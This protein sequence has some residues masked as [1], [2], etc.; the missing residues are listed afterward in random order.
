MNFSNG[1]LRVYAH[2]GIKPVGTLSETAK[3]LGEILAVSFFE[4]KSGRFDE[5]PA[6]IAEATHIRYALLGNPDPEEDLRDDP[7]E[8]FE[9][10]IEPRDQ[11]LTS[12]KADKSDE[13]V[14]I[15]SLDGRI[16]CWVLR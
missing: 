6:F 16:D 2:V 10:V 12:Q 4:D 9:L 7:T 5:F 8:D 1:S 13:L 14:S 11:T 3:V 15:I